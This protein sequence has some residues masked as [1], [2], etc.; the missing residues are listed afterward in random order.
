METLPKYRYRLERRMFD[1]DSWREY[2]IYEN[3]SDAHFAKE[4]AFMQDHLDDCHY[5]YRITE[6]RVIYEED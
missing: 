6:F 2:C 5:F 3:S 4:E 1:G